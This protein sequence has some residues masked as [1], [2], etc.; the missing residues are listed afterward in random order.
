MGRGLRSLEVMGWASIFFG[1]LLFLVDRVSPTGKRFESMTYKDAF[2]VGLLQ[3]IAL[4]PGASRSGTTL[5]AARLLG[6]ERRSAARFSF[7]LSIPVVIGA[8]TLMLSGT[9]TNTLASTALLWPLLLCFGL[10]YLVLSLLMLWLKHGTFAIFGLYRI[11]FG[12]YLL[13]VVYA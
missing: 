4:I 11:I 12:G 8:M 2:I 7:L 6:Y 3:V 1:A 5:I 9:C 10:G 13:Y